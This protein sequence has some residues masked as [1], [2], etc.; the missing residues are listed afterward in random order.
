[1]KILAAC[2]LLAA[3]PLCAQQPDQPTGQV[4]GRVICSDTN[5]PSRFAS[6]QL[7][8]DKTA[9]T[10]AIDPS[11]SKDDAGKLLAQTIL[12]IMMK[13][14]G[15][16]A[17]TD[18]DGNFSL[19]KVPPGTYYV[20]A[21]LQGYLSPLS[22]LSQAE[23]AKAD[24][25]TL[26]EVES[27]A[28]KIV[29]QAGQSAHVEVVINRGASISGIIHYDDGSPAPGVIPVLLAQQQ[30]GKW[31]EL[32]VSGFPL[33]APADDRGHYHFSG[34][35][36]GKYAVKATLPTAQTTLGFGSGPGAVAMHM[37]LGDMLAV[38]S[39]GAFREKDIKPI[40]VSSGDSI[41]GIEVVFPLND[42]HTVSG[43]VV[44]KSDQHPVSTGAVA[45]E[46]PDTKE[47]LRTTNINRDGTFQFHY[48]P[49]GQYLLKATGAGDVAE[50][51]SGDDTSASPFAQLLAAGKTTKSY[52]ESEQPVQVKSDQTGI[53]LQVPDGQTKTASGN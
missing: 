8:S 41:D 22:Q 3:L 51:G 50:T 31:K 44:A 20:I 53:M 11:K 15:L 45:L 23:R 18:I 6:V 25:A 12:N 16:S 4:T 1:M 40:E 47:S 39:S 33:P 43:S 5:T 29:V 19:N 24:P 14:S 37:D 9:S 26:Q 34:L 7:V 42:L 17:L 48:V 46:D 2:L 27:S 36:P 21:Q 30:D 52:A 35:A 13:G 28:E 10:P 49:E 38:Y 32:A